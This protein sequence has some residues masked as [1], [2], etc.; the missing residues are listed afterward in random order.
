MDEMQFHMEMVQETSRKEHH[1][2]TSS[3]GFED[4]DPS[5][6]KCSPSS[7]HT[8]RVWIPYALAHKTGDLTLILSTADFFY[9]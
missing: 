6:P 1:S 2:R 4:H 8:P 9:S 3:N 7:N 5:R